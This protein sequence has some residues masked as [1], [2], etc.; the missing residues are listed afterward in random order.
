MAVLSASDRA[1]VS[2]VVNRDAGVIQGISITKLELAAAIN[3]IDDWVDANAASFNTA[4]PQPARG[5]LSARQKAALL[6][7]VV[8]QRFSVT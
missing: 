4:I 3:A 6:M 7:Y 1:L 5:A 8:Q 2:A